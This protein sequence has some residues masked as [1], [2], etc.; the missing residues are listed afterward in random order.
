M[1]DCFFFVPLSRHF[2]AP[3]Q[4]DISRFFL[5]VKPRKRHFG[6]RKFQVT[7]S[8]Q[9]RR[10]FGSSRNFR[11]DWRD[12]PKAG[13]RLR[14]RLRLRE[15]FRRGTSRLNFDENSTESE[16]EEEFHHYSLE[17]LLRG[18]SAE[19]IYEENGRDREIVATKK[20]NV[21]V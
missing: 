18:F 13:K 20:P 11:K 2:A 17:L 3:D 19:F 12:E 5:C 16:A 15:V 9:C 6:A 14:R 8:L 1:L 7:V 10:S 21:A 4:A